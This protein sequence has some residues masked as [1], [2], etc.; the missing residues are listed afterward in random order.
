[1]SSSPAL[2]LAL[3][4]SAVSGPEINMDLLPPSTVEALLMSVANELEVNSE[5]EEEIENGNGEWELG[6]SR[7]CS[8]PWPTN[9]R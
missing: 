1:M 6:L 4:S 9:S 7:R 5:W 2:A 8:C 3:A